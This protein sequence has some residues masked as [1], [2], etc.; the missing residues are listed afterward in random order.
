MLIFV[1]YRPMVRKA[2]YHRKSGSPEMMNETVKLNGEE[3]KS[4]KKEETWWIPDNRTGIFYPKGQ[5]KPLTT[6]PLSPTLPEK[7]SGKTESIPRSCPLGNRKTQTKL[8]LLTASPLA[9]S[10]VSSSDKK[11]S[12]PKETNTVDFASFPLRN[13]RI[14]EFSSS[15]QGSWTK[16]LPFQAEPPALFQAGPAA[17][18]QAFQVGPPAPFRLQ[19]RSRQGRQG[20]RLCSRQAS[21]PSVPSRASGSV[22]AIPAGPPTPFQAFQAG[23]P[24]PFQVFQ[25]GHPAPFQVGSPAPF[26]AGPLA[27]FQAGPPTPFQAGPPFQALILVVICF[28]SSSDLLCGSSL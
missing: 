27:P 24:S 2:S 9:I 15:E 22:P 28:N 8:T 10:H 12:L 20:L 7:F 3:A 19:L 16:G 4:K 14:S 23:P 13:P 25:A 6:K 18:F 21:V 11:Y 17:P 26:Q 5:N 1:I